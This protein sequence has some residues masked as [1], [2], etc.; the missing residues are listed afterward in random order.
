M[1]ARPLGDKSVDDFLPQ[2]ES[3]EGTDLK[4]V[5]I[6]NVHRRTFGSRNHQTVKVKAENSRSLLRFSRSEIEDERLDAVQSDLLDSQ[7][8]TS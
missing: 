3:A 5:K 2:R 7:L 1:A 4:V 8:L 6:V